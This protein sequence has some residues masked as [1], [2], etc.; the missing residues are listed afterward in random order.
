[1]NLLKGIPFVDKLVNPRQV[2]STT[3]EDREVVTKSDV[4]LFCW[5]RKA[6]PEIT[7]YLEERLSSK[8]EP[9]SFFTSVNELQTSLQDYRAVWD[10]T[11]DATGD[12]FWNDVNM[13]AKDFLSFSKRKEGT[14]VLKVIANDACTKFHTDGYALRLFTTYYGN[15]TEW[16]PEKATNRKGL[17]K[18]NEQIIKDLLQ[19]RRMDPFEVG[20]LKGELPNQMN[21]TRGIV[22]RSPEIGQTGAKRV[23]LRVDI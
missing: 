9:I 21:R 20:I 11:Y 6:D 16:L 10:P 23:I 14:V 13:L 1:M 4:N 5:K 22:H 3:W 8:L 12:V 2:T 17:G 19:V 18:S 15:G 7:S